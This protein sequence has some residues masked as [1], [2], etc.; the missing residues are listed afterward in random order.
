LRARRGDVALLAR[1]FWRELGGAGELPYDLV[2]RCE[3]YRW[4]GN[5]RELYNEIVRRVALGIALPPARASAPPP[6]PAAAGS[7][8]LDS[9]LALDLPLPRA[10]ERVLDEFQRRYV[11]RV[12]ARHG[13]NVTRAAAA[14]GI[15]HRYFQILRARSTPR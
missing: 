7:D 11:E 5:V 2:Q 9:V 1:H 3:S 8:F 4:P 15:A 10:R 14:S 13:G 12:L 6:P